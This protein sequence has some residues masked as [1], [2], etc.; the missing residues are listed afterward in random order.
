MSAAEK[1]D[2]RGTSNPARIKI[3][4]LRDA[5][6]IREM[7]GLPFDEIGFVFAP[8]KRQ[9]SPELAGT[10]IEETRK[11]R[12][13]SGLA[14]STV[15]VFVNPSLQELQSVLASA[16][17]DVVQL[18]G[19]ESP[20]LC[21]QVKEA[22][23]VQV[24]KVFS[25]KDTD[26]DVSS[27]ASRLEAYAGVVDGFLIDTAGGGT[28]QTFAWHVIDR[29]MEAAAAIGV[30]LYVAGGLHPDNVADLVNQY[31]PSGVDV[32][33][34]VET[35]GLKDIHKIRLFVERVRSV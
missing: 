14:P 6:T 13:Q 4:G 28:G 26:G 25:V 10:L 16:P 27:G 3:C 8:S 32:S 30:P 7:N 21:A 34:G 31:A 17:L 33:S 29:Y 12:A 2:N 1:Q 18:H 23:N 5:A 35:D 22:L 9:V 20:E 11:L 19:E 24:W 15:G